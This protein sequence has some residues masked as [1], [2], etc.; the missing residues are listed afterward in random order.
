MSERV[1][2]DIEAAHR[3]FSA[4]C[5]NQAWDLLDKA[6][7]TPDED[8]E[9]IRLSMAS[10]WHWTER[11]DCTATSLSVGCWQ[12]SR[13]YA[14]LKQAD[15]ARRYG[16]LCVQASQ[17]EDVGPFYLGYAYEALARA[18]SVAGNRQKSDEYLGRA[19]ELATEVADPDWRQPLLADLDTI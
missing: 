2:F 17:G 11:E 4:R 3:H 5:F 12:L 7:R 1:Q 14:M 10:L 19:R 13:I 16:A 9:M 15:N 6:E 8:E 18:E